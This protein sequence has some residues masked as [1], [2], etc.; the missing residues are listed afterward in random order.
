[1]SLSDPSLLTFDDVVIDLAGHRLLRGGVEQPLEPKAFGV[2]AL[3]ATAPGR[4][5]SRDEI[6]DAVW[7]HRHITPGTLNRLMTMLRHALGEDAQ[8]PRYLHTLHGMGYRFDL[9]VIAPAVAASTTPQVTAAG[10]TATLPTP[11]RRAGD[12]TT[13]RRRLLFA[14]FALLA[15]L[16]LILLA[17]GIQRLWPPPPGAP[18]PRVADRSIAVLPL[19]NASGDA[20]QRFFSDGLSE[21]LINAPS[22]FDDLKVI[23]RMSSFRFRDSREGSAAIGRALGVAYL[24]GG[25]VQRVEGMLRITVEVVSTSYGRTLWAERY[26]RPYRDLFALQDEIARA[27]AGA[28]QAKL[29]LQP[30]APEQSDTPPSGRMEAYNAYLQGMQSFYAQ[31]METATIHQSAATR[32]DPGYAT[33]WAQL[34]VAWALIGYATGGEQAQ[35]SYRKARAAADEALR[36]SPDLGI[37]HAA[38]GNLLLTDYDWRGAITELQRATQL[39]PES[40][41]SHGGLSRAWAAS[42]HL[43]AA[44]AERRRFLTIEPLWAFNHFALADLLAAKGDLDGAGNYIDIGER[45]RPQEAPSH[46]RMYLALLRGDT[47]SAME[48]AGRQASPW[49]EMN[50]AMVAQAGA[51]RAAADAAL[52]QVE[53]DGTWART[54]P[55]SMAQAYALRGDVG[56]SVAWLEHTRARRDTRLHHLLYDPII[57]QFRNDPRLVAFCAQTGLPSPATTQALGLDEIRAAIAAK[58]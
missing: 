2:L 25:S 19:S 27:I 13:S 40:G 46:R 41:Q 24:V 34:S 8:G 38:L 50:L 18:P 48:L 4:A 33:A 56:N 52:A 5:F 31:D 28:L 15:L 55:Y 43:D 39:A 20:D 51:D 16:A 54:S 32:L 9:P 44:I 23:G 7:G 35:A 49:R 37:A 11:R 30:L 1:M 21:N 42:G 47:R 36:L 29:K 57:L 53:A 17:F 45:L 14:L 22:Q 10:P 12:G 6:L 58:R 26:D 3:L